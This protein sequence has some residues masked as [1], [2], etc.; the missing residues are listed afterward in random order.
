MEKIF[1]KNVLD[2]VDKE[3]WFTYTKHDRKHTNEI[4]LYAREI[5]N[6]FNMTL[7]LQPVGMNRQ[8]TAKKE[9][10][11]VHKCCFVKKDE[12]TLKELVTFQLCPKLYYHKYNFNSL[13]SYKDIHQLRLYAEAVLYCDVLYKFMEYNSQNKVWY[14][15]YEDKSSKALEYILN[16]RFKNFCKNFSCLTIPELT[17]IKRKVFS[18]IMS[19]INDYI[20][21][22]LG[23]YTYTVVK[24]KDDNTYKT[25]KFLLRLEYDLAIYGK[26]TRS[27]RVDEANIYLDFLTLKCTSRQIKEK[28]YADMIQA[29]KSK[30]KYVDRVFY[31]NRIMSKINVQFSSGVKSFIE[32]FDGGIDRVNCL[33]NQISN[34]NIYSLSCY[35]SNFCNYCIVKDVCL[36]NKETQRY[37]EGK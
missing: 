14:S 24:P 16:G 22:G 11:E 36:G 10:F 1:F 33:Y 20:I 23:Y 35:P 5:A 29:L 17:L 28:H 26:D 13:L 19:M 4:S 32:G 30:N 2:I 12:Y 8:L 34:A 18:R 15:A 7:K 6:V 21:N 37:L 31:A 3:I 27:K 25:S 9:D